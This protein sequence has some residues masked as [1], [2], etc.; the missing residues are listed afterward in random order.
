MPSS[1]VS[2]T[3]IS[4]SM[5][6]RRSVSDAVAVAHAGQVQ[7]VG[8]R[9]APGLRARPALEQRREGLGRAPAARHLE[10]RPDQHAVHVAHEGVRLDPELEHVARPSAHRARSTSRS[11]RT[12]SVS[13][14]VKAVKSCVPGSAARRRPAPS[15]S[16]GC[17]QCSARPRSKALRRRRGRGPGS[18]RRGWWRRGG[19]RSRRA[20]AR[21]RA[22][23]RRAAAAPF[24]APAGAGSP[25]WEATCAQRVHAARRCAR[26]R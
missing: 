22:R 26:P 9:G 4:Q 13:V 1:L 23:R 15:R 8:R 10:H 3:F 18:S 6:G 14:G 16:S 19:R 24:S 5:V 7:A 12:W 2:R 11:K 20:P 17:G 25:A 21:R